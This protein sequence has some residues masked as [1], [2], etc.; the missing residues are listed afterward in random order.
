M[1]SRLEDAAALP[2]D[3]ETAFLRVDI[4]VA[5]VPRGRAAAAEPVCAQ[6]PACCFH[7]EA[8]R[9]QSARPFRCWMDLRK[10]AVKK[11][12]A[13]ACGEQP[14]ET[15]S[16]SSSSENVSFLSQFCSQSHFF[17][18]IEEDVYA[19]CDTDRDAFVLMGVMLQDG[20]GYQIPTHATASET[21]ALLAQ[22]SKGSALKVFMDR[23]P[24]MGNAPGLSDDALG[25]K[26]TFLEANPAVPENLERET[27]RHS[28][29]HSDMRTSVAAASEQIAEELVLQLVEAS[30][31]LPVRQIRVSGADDL[32]SVRSAI[33]HLCE[34][35]DPSQVGLRL[36]PLAGDPPGGA[37]MLSNGPSSYHPQQQQQ[38]RLGDLFADSRCR[39]GAFADGVVRRVR[40]IDVTLDHDQ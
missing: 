25:R 8:N 12:P 29:R 22:S 13:A 34:V 28:R 27:R 11:P 35:D 38:L 37:T 39:T 23:V 16:S 10:L 24:A 5:G 32:Q 18:Q 30:G 20:D 2:S 14:V 9:W 31:R 6:A 26:R 36:H 4:L 40:R 15:S 1:T 3:A 21:L 33:A 19:L 17:L 7:R